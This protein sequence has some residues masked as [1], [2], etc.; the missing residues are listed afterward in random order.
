V[1]VDRALD[2]LSSDA[3][4]KVRKAKQPG[5]FEPM[6]ATL[7]E[8][9]FSREGWLFEPKL[10]G[11]RC[12]VFR[13]GLKAE[14]YSRNQKLLNS[15]YPELVEVFAKQHA[16][17][18]IVDGE[19]ITFERGVTSFAKL[20]QRM[21]IQHPSAELRKR[22]PVS[23]LCVRSSLSRRARSA[24]GSLAVQEK[25]AGEDARVPRPLAPHG[26]PRDRR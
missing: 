7:T 16:T 25:L 9:R 13:N 8:D 5:W 12:L 10:D 21:Q 19:I 15:K 26:T 20:Q 24:P 3:R 18:F 11:E 6:L 14:L 2:N 1:A 22:V 4:A 23:F 17:S